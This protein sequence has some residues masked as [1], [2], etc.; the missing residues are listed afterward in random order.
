LDPREAEA[1]GQHGITKGKVRELTT[2]DH[3]DK[4]MLI[5]A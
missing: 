3:I 5:A 1:K 2:V 4:A